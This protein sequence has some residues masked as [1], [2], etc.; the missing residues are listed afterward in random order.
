MPVSFGSGAL[1][2]DYL[3]A[4]AELDKRFQERIADAAAVDARQA[5]TQPRRPA[6]RRERDFRDAGRESVR[7][8]AA[9]SVDVHLS[10]R[11]AAARQRERTADRRPDED[12]SMRVPPCQRR[13]RWRCLLRRQRAPAPKKST[14]RAQADPTRRGRHRQRLRRRSQVSG[15][16]R[17]EVQVDADL[18]SDVR[19]AGFHRRRRAH[20]DR[21]RAAEGHAARRGS[22][23]LVVQV[24][25]DSS[26]IDQHRQRRPDDQGRARHRSACR[27]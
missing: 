15:W 27:R 9:G 14:R 21:S 1:G 18:G 13:C 16:D 10:E 4:R 23:D 6:P 24:P 5:R 8:A 17:A 3:K 11:A 25:R 26:L 12:R 19:A 22:S 20:H 7:S 2:A